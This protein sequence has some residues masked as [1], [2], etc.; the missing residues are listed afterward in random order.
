MNNPDPFAFDVDSITNIEPKYDFKENSEGKFEV[1]VDH[2]LG[3]TVRF[4]SFMDHKLELDRNENGGELFMFLMNNYHKKTISHAICD[5]YDIGF[6]VDDWVK[7]YIEYL[8]NQSS[9]YATMFKLLTTLRD[10]GDDLD[11]IASGSI[12]D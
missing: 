11:D 5:L 2:K 3:F 9:R 10:F 6:P 1:Y 4:G 8:T 12:D 7:D